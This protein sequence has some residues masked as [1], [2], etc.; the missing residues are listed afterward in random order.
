[1]ASSIEEDKA[2]TP[3]R[4]EARQISFRVSDS[5]YS[6]LKQSAE[7][8]NMSVAAYA[9]KKA[10]NSRVVAPKLDAETRHEIVRDLSGVA[11]NL[12][13]IAKWCNQNNVLPEHKQDDFI[14]KMDDLKK[15]VNEIWQRLN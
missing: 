10:Q 3:R 13:Q 8:L 9:K 15:E 12:N 1:M 2:K 14:N 6:K 5:E 4:K 11:N 7:T